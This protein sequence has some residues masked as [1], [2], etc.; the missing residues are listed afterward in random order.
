MKYLLL[1]VIAVHSL[2][3]LMGFSKPYGLATF[4]Q[5]RVPIRQPLGLLWL[6]AALLFLLSAV[7]PEAEAHWQ[8]PGGEFAYGRF[9]VVDV[10]YNVAGR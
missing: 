5:L 7:L 9:E 8:L 1:A 4:E 3:H 2:I 6:A 10:A